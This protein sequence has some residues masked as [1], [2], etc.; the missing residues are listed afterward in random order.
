MQCVQQAAAS[1]D[2]K[3]TMHSRDTAERRKSG[4]ATASL[5]R[6]LGVAAAAGAV[7]AS[8]CGQ[9]HLQWAAA[10]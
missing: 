9:S 8:A 3:R 4:K 1:Q 5:A 7:A 2:A 6:Q 10:R